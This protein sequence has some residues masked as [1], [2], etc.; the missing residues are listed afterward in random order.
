MKLRVKTTT[1][2]K[3]MVQD[4]IKHHETHHHTQALANQL[5]KI[6]EIRYPH[7]FDAC[8]RIDLRKLN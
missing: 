4:N 5:S 2:S 7:T 6:R 3:T 1:V 8:V